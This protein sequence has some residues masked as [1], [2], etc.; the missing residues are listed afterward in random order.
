M[1][2]AH[3]AAITLAFVLITGPALLFAETSVDDK[4]ACIQA[5][6]L[7]PEL[8]E[9]GTYK[10]RVEACVRTRQ[11]L[12]LSQDRNLRNTLRA[13]KVQE[14]LTRNSRVVNYHTVATP[15][16][17]AEKQKRWDAIYGKESWLFSVPIARPSR[18]TIQKDVST[19]NKE[20]RENNGALR[21][22][23]LLEALK[24]CSHLTSSFHQKNCVR[25]KL[26]ELGN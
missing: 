18:R 14:R 15:E 8:A 26:T 11:N 19:G 9:T 17:P 4:Q 13:E 25:A 24:F 21:R 20:Q 22:E 5:L 1:T 10:V 3:P 23:R 6:Q 12:R 2:I 16:I 7:T